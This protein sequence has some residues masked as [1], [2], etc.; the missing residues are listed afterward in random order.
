[1]SGPCDDELYDDTL[2]NGDACGY[3]YKHLDDCVGESILNYR[4]AFFCGLKGN[5]YVG[6]PIAVFS[7]VIHS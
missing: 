6:A 5:A 7:F 4:I 1:M 3:I 2:I